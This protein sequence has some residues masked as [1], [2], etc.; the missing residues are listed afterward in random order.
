LHRIGWGMGYRSEK[1]RDL[2]ETGE[3]AAIRHTGHVEF[4]KITKKL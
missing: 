3:K 4:M 2:N 1:A